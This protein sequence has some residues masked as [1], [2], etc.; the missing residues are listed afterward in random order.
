MNLQARDNNGW[1]HSVAID[2]Q[3]AE[4]VGDQTCRVDSRGYAYLGKGEDLT[5]LHHF[6]LGDIV[7]VKF[8]D[9]NKLNCHRSNLEAQ[10]TA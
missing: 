3:D 10:G 2:A 4:L 1:I 8:L 5:L 9:G 6:L 7:K